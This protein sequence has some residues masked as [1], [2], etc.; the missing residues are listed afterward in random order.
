M[1]TRY[2]VEQLQ[3]MP[4]DK[5][6]TVSLA[7]AENVLASNTQMARV[8]VAAQKHFDAKHTYTQW[9]RDTFGEAL[10]VE[11]ARRICQIYSHPQVTNSALEYLPLGVLRIL[12]R[13]TTPEHIVDHCRVVTQN[14]LGAGG[15]SGP[16]KHRVTMEFVMG[17]VDSHQKDATTDRKQA[18][19]E[20]AKAKQAEFKKANPNTVSHITEPPRPKPQNT[21]S[22]P[23]PVEQPYK[24]EKAMPELTTEQVQAAV[25]MYMKIQALTE[26][27]RRR[28]AAI[29]NEKV[30]GPEK[31]SA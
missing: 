1:Q 17:L 16:Y 28:I 9:V 7:V 19:L 25:E 24:Q 23:K 15:P 2:T 13:N 22:Q 11:K 27:Q 18:M 29:I 14:D 20:E 6:R 31:V 12:A 4:V 10:S 21:P 30:Q 8:L 3:G 26:G 5:F